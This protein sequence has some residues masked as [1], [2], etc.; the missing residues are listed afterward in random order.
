MANFKK[1][2]ISAKR[3]ALR[4]RSRLNTGIDRLRV[5]IFRSLKHIHVQ[6]ID[7]VKHMTL[8]SCSTVQ[9]KNISGT[10]KEQAHAI[11]LELARK[12]L[13]KGITAVVVDRGSARYHGRVKSLVEGM[14]E[15]GLQV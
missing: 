12:A 13:D 11:G 15:G 4:V 2:R 10:K 1:D 9:M 14:R 7:D 8:A 6:V 5:S 3:R